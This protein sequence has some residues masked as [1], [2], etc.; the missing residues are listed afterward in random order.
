MHREDEKCIK[1]WEGNLEEKR[2]LGR[3]GIDG[4]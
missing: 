4:R 3:Q 1:N 2:P